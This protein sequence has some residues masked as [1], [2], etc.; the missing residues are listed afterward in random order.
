[1]PG[2]RQVRCHR[3]A[4][5]SGEIC[6]VPGMRAMV[7]AALVALGIGAMGCSAG[8]G[9]RPGPVASSPGKGPTPSW[10]P[11]Y[12]PEQ[13]ALLEPPD[14]PIQLPAAR[15]FPDLARFGYASDHRMEEP[16]ESLRFVKMVASVL[17]DS[18][19]FYV[20]KEA[21]PE[22][23]NT[24][25]QYG[26]AG[27]AEP[28]EWHTL[29]RD[30]DGA[31]RLVR[32][33]IA[34][35]AREA[36][37][38]GEAL[39]TAGDAASARRAFDEALARSPRH[40]A[41]LV[42]LG[43]ALVAAGDL[44]AAEQA[45]QRALAVDATLGSAHAGLA[46]VQERR[47]DA[48]AARRHLA[49][50]LAYHPSSRRAWALANRITP[51]GAGQGR[52][53][54][55]AIFLDVDS[56]GAVHVGSGPTGAAQ[57]YAGCRAILRYEPEVR[58]AIFRQPVGTPYYLSVVEEVVCLE[59]AIGAYLVEQADAQRGEDPTTPREPAQPPPAE[60]DPRVESLA[61]LAHVEGL[62]GYAMFEILGM[63]RPER[64]RG[65]PPA[66]H[67]AVVRYV[68]QYILG[69]GG[70]SAPEGVYTAAR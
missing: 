26:P 12:T 46:E 41:A 69:P 67:K 32:A 70:A 54:P 59:A 33:P 5:H 22:L 48:D 58:A 45:F 19:R 27:P 66:L 50:A 68:E 36:H 30:R 49:E 16:E 1:M 3:K 51:G 55:F 2:A 42:G 21:R 29:Q 31:G 63:H 14:V 10:V 4:A 44:G 7:A 35:E 34:A 18:P 61:R 37:A 6:Y 47:G 57:I 38:R 23:A 64:A 39:L 24:V 60:A 52:V 40:P 13:R 43:R 28:D 53:E 20:L 62:S 25:A 56:V 9:A 17:T 15:T 8:V 65:A 11:A